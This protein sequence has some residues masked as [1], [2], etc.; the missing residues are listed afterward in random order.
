MKKMFFIVFISIAFSGYAQTENNLTI[1]MEE[2]IDLGIKN[3]YDIQANKYN[4][5]IAANTVSKRKKEWLPDISASVNVEYNTQLKAMYVPE[6]FVGLTEPS[7]IALGSKNATAFS[8]DLNQALYQPGINTDIK[9]AKNNL[10]LQKEKNRATEIEIKNQIAEAYLNV[11][12]KKLQYEVAVKDEN[13]YEEYVKLAEGRYKQGVLIENDY[14]Q[15]QLDYENAKIQTTTTKQRYELSLDNLKYQINVPEETIVTLSD[16]IGGANFEENQEQLPVNI[17]NQ[18]EVKQLQLQQQANAL[19]IKKMRQ[20]ALPTISLFASYSQQF[21]YKNF[22]Y[23]KSN[24]WSPYSY[25]GLRLSLPITS[26]FKNYNNVQR[27]K[28]R[29]LQTDLEIKQKTA[30]VDYELEKA[31]T[32]LEN[33][34]ENMQITQRNYALSQ[35]I[36]ATQKQQFALGAFKYSDLL[37][38]E[39]S[40][41]RTEQNYLKAVYDYLMAKISIEKLSEIFK[42]AE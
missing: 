26:D 39:K 25:L 28:I 6:G 11:L 10:D 24:W 36:E 8:L 23:G 34:L 18:T 42:S 5:T 22:E 37:D 2:A 31:M 20:N 41:I 9:L 12:L 4:I 3:R 38:T 21:L 40:L 13:R 1:T 29:T 35:T 17:N 27:Y 32:E 15:V 7:L 33:A 19:Q 30:D 16:T 14:R